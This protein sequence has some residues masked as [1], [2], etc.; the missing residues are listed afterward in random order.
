MGQSGDRMKKK[1][2][3]ILKLFLTASICALAVAP[4][5]STFAESEAKGKL[6]HIGLVWLNQ[7]DHAPDRQR[8]VDALHRFA[9]EIP[10]VQSLSLGEAP[11]SSSQM[12]DSSFDLCFIMKFDDQAALD[13]YAKHPVHQ[14]AAEE[15]FLPLCRKILF[16]D[17]IGE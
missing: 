8:L 6:V 17:F 5:K 7:P 14:K 13:R 15:D 16:Y 10:E 2:P 4:T 9:R 1:S 12:V 3:F 11:P